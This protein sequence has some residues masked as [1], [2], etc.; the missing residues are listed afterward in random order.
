MLA[1]KKFKKIKPIPTELPM[2]RYISKSH[3]NPSSV[4]GK[5][6]ISPHCLHSGI[7]INFSSY[8]KKYMN[9]TNTNAVLL[10]ENLISSHPI[11]ISTI[12]SYN[13]NPSFKRP[14]PQ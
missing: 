10:F 14:Q 3:F 11:S 2:H 4:P 12:F 8:F 5:S 1:P 6:S 7:I 13:L 9:K